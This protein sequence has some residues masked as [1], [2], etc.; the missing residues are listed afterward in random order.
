MAELILG[1]IGL[2]K[3]GRPLLKV[4]SEHYAVMGYDIDLAARQRAQHDVIES[5][6]VDE[7]RQMIHCDVLFLVP[8]TPEKPDGGFDR[9]IIESLLFALGAETFGLEVQPT[10]VIVSTL[11][12]GDSVALAGIYSGELIYCPAFIRQGTVEDDFKTPAFPRQ[13]FVSGS[14]ALRRNGERKGAVSQLKCHR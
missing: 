11:F 14:G 9:G 8:P 13:S 3:V 6:V 1:V 4:L 12:P 5:T 10:V 2:G 7:L